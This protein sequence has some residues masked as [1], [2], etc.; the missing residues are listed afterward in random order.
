MYRGLL[1]HSNDRTLN[2]RFTGFMFK[3]SLSQADYVAGKILYNRTTASKY[4][5]ETT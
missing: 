4:I 5:K 3:L 1:P 2:Y